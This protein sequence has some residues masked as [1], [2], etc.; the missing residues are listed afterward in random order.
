MTPC[1]RRREGEVPLVLSL[2]A[3]LKRM[4]R[5]IEVAAVPRQIVRRK[6]E[7]ESATVQVLNRIRCD[8]SNWTLRTGQQCLV[9]TRASD[10]M[11]RFAARIPQFKRVVL[12]TIL[13][14]Q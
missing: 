7:R 10:Q 5:G 8:V 9:R 1:V 14:V 2:H 11:S 13:P 3:E 4:V 12:Q 6:L